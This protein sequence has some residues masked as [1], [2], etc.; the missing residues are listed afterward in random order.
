MEEDDAWTDLHVPAATET[1]EARTDHTSSNMHNIPLFKPL[2][3]AVQSVKLPHGRRCRGQPKRSTKSLNIK[4]KTTRKPKR[5]NADVINDS[6]C[7]L[8]MADEPSKRLMSGSS[9]IQWTECVKN[10][11]RWFHDVCI[12][13]IGSVPLGFLCEICK[14]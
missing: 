3:D 8:C 14:Q 2:G 9:I 10:C 11:G 5:A 1:R 7:Y 6:I 12:L 13:N 4:F